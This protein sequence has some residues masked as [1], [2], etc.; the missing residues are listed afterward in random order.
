MTDLSQEFLQSIFDYCEETGVLTRK[1]RPRDHFTSDRTFFMY[2]DMYAGSVVSAYTDQGYLVARL[3]KKLHR[4]H[5]VAWIIVN[6]EIPEGL[7]IDHI[8]GIRDDN[9]ISNLRCC[10]HKQN[11]RNMFGKEKINGLPLGV[12]YDKSRNCY[13]ASV[14]L[15]EKGKAIKKR[16][17]T[18]SEASAW[19][20]SH[21][22]S[23][24]YDDS[25]GKKGL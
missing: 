10:S 9:R 16:F 19:R 14:G 24:N 18:V 23:L 4:A 11:L 3:G 2:N 21:T 25:H 13:S 20:D 7:V 5:R 12:Y 15:G 1:E 17:S 6:G 8:N 22:K